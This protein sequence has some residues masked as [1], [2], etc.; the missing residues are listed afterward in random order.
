MQQAAAAHESR[1]ALRAFVLRWTK[2]A[3]ALTLPLFA[4]AALDRESFHLALLLV[5]FTLV[6]PFILA[7]WFIVGLFVSINDTASAI[8]RAKEWI[9]LAIA[10]A[11]FFVAI[12]LGMRAAAGLGARAHLYTATFTSHDEMQ[13]AIDRCQD[14]PL[15][16]ACPDPIYIADREHGRYAFDTVG[17]LDEWDGIVYDPEGKLIEASAAYIGSPQ[18]PREA[19]FDS[20]VLWCRHLRADYYHCGFA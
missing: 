7:I 14:H 5:I 10:G 11:F 13:A 19:T 2:I 18:P 3:A 1:E 20:T 8:T 4:F 17:F 6:G 16:T 12:P 15:D 9:G